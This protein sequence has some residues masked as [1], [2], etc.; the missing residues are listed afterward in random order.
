MNTRDVRSMNK[1][2]VFAKG[3]CFDKLFWI[4]V[5][6][7]VFGAYYEELLVLIKGLIHQ[8]IPI[9]EYRRGVIYGPFSPVY[10][11]GAVLMVYL[12]ARNLKSKWMTF[13]F[14][15]LF[16]GLFE[17]IISFLQ[18]TFIGTTSWDYSNHFLNIAG[19]TTIPIMIAW[20]ILTVFLIHYVYPSV[21][22]WIEKVP[23]DLGKKV[24]KWMLIFL[25]IDMLVSWTALFRWTLRRNE[26]EPVTPVGKIYDRIYPDDYLQ[27]RFPNMEVKK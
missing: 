17:F 3:F 10:G 14:G 15:S 11:F 13:L 7:C 20:G 2:E 12:F 24:T 16:G 8:G 27:K 18:E 9:M 26:I 6:G 1:N 5:I 23:Y 19:R 25:V 21:S 4:F 22:K